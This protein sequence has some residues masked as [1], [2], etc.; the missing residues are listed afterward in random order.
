MFSGRRRGLLFLALL[1]L[2]AGCET[3]GLGDDEQM[4][5]SFAV[6]TQAGTSNQ[7]FSLVADSIIFGGHTLNLQNVDITFDEITVERAE[8]T[9]GGD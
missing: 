1:A 6:G 8:L 3:F 9:S 2:P 5:V 7:S 4:S